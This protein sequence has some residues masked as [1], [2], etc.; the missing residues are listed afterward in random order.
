MLEQ[1]ARWAAWVHVS[2]LIGGGMLITAASTRTWDGVYYASS[3][4]DGQ[5][6]FALGGV[7]VLL[8]TSRVIIPTR[9]TRLLATILGLWLST[10]VGMNAFGTLREL[11]QFPDNL[12]GFLNPQPQPALY[13]T[14]AGGII[15]GLGSLLGLV[16][17]EP[18]AL[19]WEKT[20][21]TSENI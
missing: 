1:L 15:T 13:A 16:P 20:D 9:A 7:A 3:I 8:G 11:G 4:T 5:I 18:D 2:A 19:P 14:L 21:L 17:A 6:T 12:L 10:A